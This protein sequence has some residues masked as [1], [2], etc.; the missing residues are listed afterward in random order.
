MKEIYKY[1]GLIVAVIISFTIV[2]GIS[3]IDDNLKDFKNESI[4][5]L[6]YNIRFDRADKLVPSEENE[7]TN[8]KE[9]LISLI[10]LHSPDFFGL[11]EDLLHQ[12]NEID[13]RFEDYD[14]IGMGRYDGKEGGEFCSIHY[15]S[16]RFELL[17]NRTI[18]LSETPE[19]PST[20][21]D[22]SSPRVLNYGKFKS[23]V[24]GKEF[25]VFNTHF[26]HAGQ[27]AREGSAKLIRQMINELSSDVSFIL[28]GDFNITEENIV[29]EILTT[30][31]S[32]LKDAFNTSEYPHV[33]PLFTREGFEVN[34]KAKKRRIDYIF[35]SENIGVKKHAIISSFRDG[36]YPSDHLPVYTEVEL[37]D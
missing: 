25:Y 32:M 37:Y 17:E 28:M 29:Y 16:T 20:S 9:H 30:G 2:S 27:K 24:S 1:F 23:R 21:W 7:W 13:G 34:S 31:E 26:D 8:R 11:Q 5:I 19:E 12:L 35:V 10:Q 36:Y 4:S 33:G 15:N 18:W 6:S 14:W 3:K 22:G